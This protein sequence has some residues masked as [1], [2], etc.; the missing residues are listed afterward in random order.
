MFVKLW[1]CL[2]ILLALVE[3]RPKEVYRLHYDDR[4]YARDEFDFIIVGGGGAGCVVARTLSDHG[5]SVLIIERG[6]VPSREAAANSLPRI[7]HTQTHTY[8]ASIR[9]R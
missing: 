2:G 9:T 5:F 7:V 6:D 8:T 4:G 3:G 1:V